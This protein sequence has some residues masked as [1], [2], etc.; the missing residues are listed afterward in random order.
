MAY[1]KNICKNC[2]NKAF[3]PYGCQ[4]EL[5]IAGSANECG[6]YE[7]EKDYGTYEFSR[8]E[9]EIPVYEGTKRVA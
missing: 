9:S 8:T 7:V 1:E 4:N 3:N 2:I 5:S 6:N